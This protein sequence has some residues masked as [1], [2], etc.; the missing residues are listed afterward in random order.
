MESSIAEFLQRMDACE[1]HPTVLDDQAP[2][3]HES[4]WQGHAARLNPAKTMFVGF[5]SGIIR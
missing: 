4:W 5:P 2:V 1:L 3:Q